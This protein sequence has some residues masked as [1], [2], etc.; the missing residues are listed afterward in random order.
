MSVDFS[1]FRYLSYAQ[2]VIFASGS[3]NRLSEAID[4]FHW[5]RLM[6]CTS[7]SVKSNGQVGLLETILGERL[8]TIYDHVQPHVQDTQV[9]EALALASEKNVEAVIGMGRRTP[10]ATPK[11]D[12][13]P[14]QHGRTG[15]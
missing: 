11:P 1:E 7:R 13:S 12:A 8:V 5:Q 2:E 6:L 14:F 4:R 10:I 3:I 15:H 9:V